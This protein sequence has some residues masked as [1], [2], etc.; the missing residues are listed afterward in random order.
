MLAGVWGCVGAYVCGCA[1]RCMHA[2]VCFVFIYVFIYDLMFYVFL[3]I[4]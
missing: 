1:H 2:L 3:D 4:I